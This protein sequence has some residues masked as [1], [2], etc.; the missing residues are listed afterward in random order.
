MHSS[1]IFYTK[2]ANFYADYA[3]SKAKYLSAVDDFIITEI[4]LP[5]NIIDIGSGD[6][7]RAKQIADILGIKDLTFLD[8]SAGMID[9]ANKI[10]GVKIIQANIADSNF[11]ADR[12]YK[13]VLCLW[14]VFGHIPSAE[15]RKIALNNLVK[16]TANDGLIFLDVNN[17]YNLLQYGVKSAFKN[18]FKDILLPKDLNGDFKLKFNIA[19]ELIQTN[20]HIFNPF[21]IQH[22]IKSAGLKILKRQIINYKSGEKDKNI[23]EGQL[24]YKLS[25][26]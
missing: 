13:T 9:L 14:N 22:L 24:V 17:R 2:F 23:F 5:D 6:G 20:V 18:I 25:K 7:K 10:R 15:S 21:E 26:I 1:D 4:G 19:G 3:A 11:R 8:N 12:E 16:L